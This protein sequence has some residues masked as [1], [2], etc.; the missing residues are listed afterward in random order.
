[1]SAQTVQSALSIQSTKTIQPLKWE[2]YDGEGQSEHPLICCWGLDR[3]SQSTLV[4]IENY[5][6][7]CC[8]ELP[9]IRGLK[10]SQGTCSDLVI[11]LNRI[12][13]DFPIV[14]WEF[15]RW[16][17][18]YYVQHHRTPFLRA[19]FTN[20]DQ[21]RKFI[22]R[23][24][25]K[26]NGKGEKYS[27]FRL[28]GFE[29][30]ILEFYETDIPLDTQLLADL[31]LGH[32]Q[33]FT[34]PVN[35]TRKNGA[36]TSTQVTE[37]KL[38]ESLEYLVET[39]QIKPLPS[40]ET[41][42]WSVH[43]Q[44]CSW[45]IETYSPNH[46]AMPN[47]NLIKHVAY[48]ISCVFERLGT[49]QPRKRYAI[50]YGS[51][52]QELTEN[53][54]LIQVSSEMELIKVFAQ[55][56]RQE[57]TD[58][59]VGYNTNGYDWDYLNSRLAI[60][61]EKWPAMGR[62]IGKDDKFTDSFFM[63]ARYLRISG[64]VN[65]DMLTVIRREHKLLKYSLDYVSKL[66]LKRGKH[67]VSA[68][69]MFKIY[70]DCQLAQESN[71][72]QEREAAQEKMTKVMLYCLE[73]SE[74]VLDLMKKFDTHTATIQMSNVSGVQYEDFHVRGQQIRVFSRIYRQALYSQVVTTTRVAPTFH[75][76]GG[77]VGQPKPGIYD[78]VI[79]VDFKSMYP[80]IIRA[81][82]ICYTT[83]IPED[84]WSQYPK[85]TYHQIVFEQEEE[86]YPEYDYLDEKGRHQTKPTLV[87]VNYE[88]RFLKEPI[89]LL[90]I[91]V[92]DLI[93]ERNRVRAMIKNYEDP[94]MRNIL[95]CR[96]LGL[97]VICNAFYGFLGFRGDGA[98]R[99][100]IEAAMSI[101]AMGR[102]L[103]TT[104]NRRCEEEYGAIV[105][106]NDTDSS[107]V[108]LPQVETGLECIKA[109]YQLERDING[110]DPVYDNEGR[111][112][113]E[114][115]EGWFPNPLKV[116]FEK[117]MRMLCIKK[118]NYAACLID[119]DGTFTLDSEGQPELLIRG[120]T[121]A[122]RD[123][124]KWV[125]EVY[126][127]LLYLVLYRVP[128]IQIV[129]TLIDRMS[130][131]L[132]HRVP[133]EKLTFVRKLGYVYSSDSAVM[134]VFAD[135]LREK[136][137][138]VKAGDRL[139]YLV[140]LESGQDSKTKTA[141]KMVYF[142]Y[143]QNLPTEEKPI[144]DV[145]YYIL[146]RF[147]KPVTTLVTIPYQKEFETL[148]PHFYVKRTPRSK[149]T[150]LASPVEFIYYLWTQKISLQE[151][152]ESILR[153]YRQCFTLRRLNLNR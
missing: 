75:Y 6:P 147:N 41:L 34:F 50:L 48:M 36:Q 102:E 10:W 52:S 5:L 81:Y 127:E 139:E 4:R 105:V 28:R 84:Q 13:Q 141:Y 99:S 134:K 103:I 67:D 17:K 94:I 57:E 40:E 30:I 112:V 113:K 124:C 123:N 63:D 43:P 119:D 12:C 135:R 91:L 120:I 118:K 3:D 83:L 130:D 55:I 115:K 150:T 144:I 11:Q 49:D 74:L 32:A 38:S 92:G 86:F 53:T 47:K 107:M 149:A 66:F 19:Y 44:V 100:L 143:Y 126:L 64:R 21:M 95:N 1:M 54:Q 122:R 61:L 85:G 18:L 114:G 109:G 98:K 116:E 138:F 140:A 128:F 16:R 104:V 46:L 26:V 7:R 80:N 82:N 2:I 148:A 35:Y 20:T 111:L 62:F 151:V 15:I 136:G 25:P 142:D 145:E 146:N 79:C 27:P 33:W 72:V 137:I 101:T 69:D 78:N 45:D 56:I 23:M 125:N 93:N 132:E 121:L 110:I 129:N 58:V 73:D 97:K 59:L 87:I 22:N 90:P 60:H 37:A 152:K 42:T 70:E 131:L 153:A 29:D 71:S 117:G 8:I 24:K 106:Y 96:Q 89:G 76:T 77:F 39:Y 68:I 88:F 133:T 51:C 9:S 14:K 65:I 108:K 31:N